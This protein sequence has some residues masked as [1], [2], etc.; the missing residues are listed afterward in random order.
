MKRDADCAHEPVAQSRFTGWRGEMYFA[1]EATSPTSRRSI[2]HAAFPTLY[3]PPCRS[4]S[5]LAIVLIRPRVVAHEIFF[6]A[7]A[8]FKW[9]TSWACLLGK[10]NE[11]ERETPAQKP[12]QHYGTVFAPG[13]VCAPFLTIGFNFHHFHCLIRC[14]INFPLCR[15]KICC[16]S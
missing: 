10:G 13:V 15:W 11:L 9:D 16:A 5:S 6:V 8:L 7:A 14:H 4:F 3:F 2:A 12:C 1:K